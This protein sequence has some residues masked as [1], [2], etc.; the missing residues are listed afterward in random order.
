MKGGALESGGSR[1]LQPAQRSRL[2]ADLRGC[3]AP[4]GVCSTTPGLRESRRLV[5][6][7]W[8]QIL[9]AWRKASTSRPG[10][11]CED[12]KSDGLLDR[13]DRIETINSR[14][15]A[16][17]IAA[18]GDAGYDI[19]VTVGA[20]I[21]DETAAAAQRY[22]DAAFIGVEQA[23]ADRDSEPG[24]AGISR[25]TKRIPGRRTGR[26]HDSDRPRC[27]RVRGEFHRFNPPV[28]RGVPGRCALRRSDGAGDAFLIARAALNCCSTIR[29]GVGNRHWKCSA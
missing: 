11:R 4:G 25:R 7:V 3:P 6:R 17:N 18:F 23:P 27:C 2:E 10:W 20:S 15:R 26:L 29:I 28:L 13:V 22:P 12:A 9:G 24:G 19:V 5:R 14:D 16:A 1:D 8:S 21:S